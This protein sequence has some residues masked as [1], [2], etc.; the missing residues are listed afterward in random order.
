VSK[1]NFIITRFTH[2]SAGKFLSTVLQTSDVIDHWSATIQRYKHTE[3]FEL[4]VAEYVR[5]SFPQNHSQ[6]LMSEPMVPYNIDLYSSGY[7]RGN[8]ITLDQYI[9]NAT[10]KNDT[11]LLDCIKFNLKANLIFHKPEIPLFCNN[12]SVVT[13]LVTSECEKKWLYKTLWSKQFL[14]TEQGIRYLPCDPEYCN[15]YSLV[16]VLTYNNQ[17]LFPTSDKEKLY[18]DYVI[19]D[20]T[21]LWY[22]DPNKF[23]DYDNEHQLNNLFI[24]LEDILVSDKF[25]STITNIF[26]QHNLGK[27]DLKLINNMHQ[28]WLSRQI[29]YDSQVSIH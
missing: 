2:G 8:N 19:N 10:I 20:R 28:I 17:Y 27:P 12:S 26:N 5:R 4:L 18:N 22:V 6:H 11:R 3:L 29:P 7:T 9:A 1:V 24:N 25:L 15:F 21:N 13:I 16:P 23:V 14:E